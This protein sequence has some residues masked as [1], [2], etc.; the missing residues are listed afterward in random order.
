VG[1]A[2]AYAVVPANGSVGGEPEAGSEV[3]V[4]VAREGVVPFVVFVLAW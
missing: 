4:V 3:G 1:V 2:V